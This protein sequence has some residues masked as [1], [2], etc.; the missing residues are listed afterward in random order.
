MIAAVTAPSNGRQ[1]E[2]LRDAN[3]RAQNIDAGLA[4]EEATS[5]SPRIARFS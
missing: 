3:E 1:G 2:A 4:R 5:V